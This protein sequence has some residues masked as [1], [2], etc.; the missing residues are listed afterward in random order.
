MGGATGS[1]SRAGVEQ[2]PEPARPP[3]LGNSPHHRPLVLDSAAWHSPG[4]GARSLPA[5]SPQEPGS[6]GA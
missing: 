1:V 4:P 3:V 6:Q 2:M 5:A